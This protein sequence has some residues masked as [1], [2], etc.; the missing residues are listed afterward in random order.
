[1]PRR[2]YKEA[3]LSDNLGRFHQI[4]RMTPL[5]LATALNACASE[6]IVLNSERIQ[7]QFG[8][9]GV[10]V[11]TNEPGLRRS[12]LYSVAEDDR[13]CR[14]YAI[15]RFVGEMD[16]SYSLEHTKVLEGNSLGNVFKTNGWDIRKQ[17]LHIG[18]ISIN[19]TDGQI[20]DLMRL[21]AERSL[22]LHVYQLLL[23]KNKQIFE[24]ATILEVHHPDY[25]IESELLDIYPYDDTNS[26][27]RDTLAQLEA[28]IRA[29]EIR[30]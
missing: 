8:S 19:A 16:D 24:Y 15:V 21:V 30:P 23:A 27:S 26:L 17:T 11:L 29:R 18:S 13:I 20:F 25:L 2:H 6:P 1:M 14:T 4:Y 9:Y 22:A 7:Q 10:D 5:V 3:K 12:S 28:L